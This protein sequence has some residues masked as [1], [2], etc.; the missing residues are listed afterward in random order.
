MPATHNELFSF[1]MDIF[2]YGDHILYFVNIQ[3]YD[4]MQYIYNNYYAYIITINMHI[5]ITIMFQY[6]DIM[7]APD[8]KNIFTWKFNILTY[9]DDKYEIN[10]I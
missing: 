9:D 7:F 2:F 3:Y 6:C 4:N 5:L 1:I 10:V 8:I